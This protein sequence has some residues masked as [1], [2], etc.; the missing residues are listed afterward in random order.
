MDINLIHKNNPYQ[1]F[2][3]NSFPLDL[4]GW[5]STDNNFLKLIDEIQPSLIIE[6]GTWKEAQPYLWEST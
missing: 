5:G 6:V 3:F 4:Q 2:D 1:G